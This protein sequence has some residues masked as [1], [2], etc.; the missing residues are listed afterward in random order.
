MQQPSSSFYRVSRVQD[1]EVVRTF[2]QRVYIWM[3]GA[4]ALTGF[5]AYYA[6]QSEQ[7][8]YFLLSNPATIY[9][10]LFGTLGIALVMGFAA[11]RLPTIAVGVLYVI[12]AA[13]I[14]LVFSTLFLVYTMQSIAQV[15]F[16]TSGMFGAMSLYGLITKRSLAS[17]GSFLTMGL[18]GII[19]AMI[20]NMFIGSS[21]L[22]LG[23]SILGVLIFLGLTAYDTQKLKDMAL[24]HGEY[25]NSSDKP[26]IYGAFSLY[27]DFINMFLF[28]L[29]IL[30]NRR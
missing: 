3:T 16:I 22:S 26:A 29:R 23:V 30:G 21:M 8:M 5:V 1:Q 24:G 4:L 12:Y 2:L 15:F 20:V 27:L 13:M 17:W 11:N 18:I 6:S 28:L 7:I 10:M 14:G 9:M 19:I 25:I